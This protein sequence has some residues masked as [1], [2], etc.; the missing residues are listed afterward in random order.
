M[1]TELIK[2]DHCGV[3]IY[4]RKIGDYSFNPKDYERIATSG[5]VVN[6]ERCLLD[7]CNEECLLSE[8]I[9]RKAKC[10]APKS[11]S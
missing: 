3:T 9:D 11:S 4:E 1:N 8:L 6:G 2:C 7:F 10:Q 5:L